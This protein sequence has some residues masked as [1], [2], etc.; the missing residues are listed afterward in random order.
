MIRLKA[1][2]M[3]VC[4]FPA[5]VCAGSD[6]PAEW[7]RPHAGTNGGGYS[8]DERARLEWLA[9]WR[10]VPSAREAGRIARALVPSEIFPVD[11]VWLS[12][13][14]G[15][16]LPRPE[17][18]KLWR[19]M[20]LQDTDESG[21]AVY[22]NA[23]FG[24]A[25]DPFRIMPEEPR[26]W[27]DFN[28]DGRVDLL[29]A[30]QGYF[31][32]SYGY[33]AVALDGDSARVLIDISSGLAA[34]KRE[35]A[36]TILRFDV[37]KIDP[38]EAQIEYFLIADNRTGHVSHGPCLAYASETVLPQA[39]LDKPRTL[40]PAAREVRTGLLVDD[41]AV[42]PAEAWRLEG[43]SVLAGN[44]VARL[45]PGGR[46]T[47]LATRPGWLFEAAPP[48]A[49]LATSLRHGMD[50]EGPQKKPRVAYTVC[51]WLKLAP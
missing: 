27:Y 29:L 38:S 11:V 32:P 8:Q 7:L 4:L 22:S 20:Q 28:A 42:D 25:A 35:S 24:N 49:V 23:V 40:V 30:T 5:A 45:R 34:V 19:R 18:E 47:V 3:G 15:F 46:V 31:G 33:G 2:A 37:M 10:V 43:T 14:I 9:S 13:R 6:W 12:S 39:W 44:V 41:T 48:E 1:L 26:G 36:R 50:E 16:P 51:G 21:V 17:R